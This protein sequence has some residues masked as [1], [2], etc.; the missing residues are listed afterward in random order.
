MALIDTELEVAYCLVLMVWLAGIIRCALS[1]AYLVQRNVC[2]LVVVEQ[3]GDELVG[4]Q[5]VLSHHD[6]YKLNSDMRHKDTAVL[7][8]NLRI[9]LL[10]ED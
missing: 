7:I 6:F 2:R 8:K 3:S 1:T 9:C 10:L 5:V 4:L